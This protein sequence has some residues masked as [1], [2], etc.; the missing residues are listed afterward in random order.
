MRIS[1]N[2]LLAILFFGVFT[3]SGY[4]FQPAFA[5]TNVCLIPDTPVL[6]SPPGYSGTGDNTPTFDWSDAN[7]ASGY[8]I[9][10]DDDLDFLPPAID[11]NTILSTFTSSTPL[12]DSN[13]FWR[14]R[15][16]NDTSGCNELGPWSV[17]S[18]LLITT[19]GP[20]SIS[21]NW[22]IS[23]PSVNGQISGSEWTDAGVYDIRSPGPLINSGPTGE[24]T[25]LLQSDIQAAS[26]LTRSS[27]PLSLTAAD[28][29]PVTLYIK[30]SGSFLYLAI[31]NPND[32]TIYALD[33]MGI[34]FDDNP[35]P[36]DGQWTQSTCGNADGEGNFYIL[37]SETQF[38]EWVTGPAICPSVITPAPGVA[39]AISY[40]SGHLQIEVAIGL[41]G[42]ALRAAPGDSI[43]MYLWIYDFNSQIFH[44]KWP[45]T[46][47]FSDP[48]T[49]GSVS[50][51]DSSSVSI[52]YLPFLIR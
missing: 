25:S 42:S 27:E 7:N 44:G 6:L 1:R 18:Y 23:I 11:T 14:V 8:Q 48:S 10:V 51:A 24:T 43:N 30:N 19:A 41:Q 36:S 20:F 34:Y 21:S 52:T 32:T 45:L 50:L 17:T 49:F 15:G 13:Y 47:Y 12:S 28:Y 46:G 40:S 38:R 29:L 16:I 35:L 22:A 2:I 39:G 9:Q 31:D 4:Y 33:Q 5:I 26:L 3:F 37:A